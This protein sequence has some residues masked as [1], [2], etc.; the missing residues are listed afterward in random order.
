MFVVSLTYLVDLKEVDSHLSDHVDYLERYY[1][2]GHFLASGRKV[3]R[4]GGVILAKA[5]SREALDAILAED[6]FMIHSVAKYD[7][8]EFTA[9]KSSPELSSLVA[10]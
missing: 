6:P 1:A 4:S 7:V 5:E 3:P 9:T 8:I 10:H 2:S